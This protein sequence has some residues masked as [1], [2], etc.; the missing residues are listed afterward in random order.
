MKKYIAASLCIC[1]FLTLP[2]TA[3]ASENALDFQAEYEAMYGEAPVALDFTSDADYR[4]AY[5]LWLSGLVSYI[6]RRTTEVNQKAAQEAAQQ[7][8]SENP[9]E[10]NE[11]AGSNHVVPSD[12]ADPPWIPALLISILSNHVSLSISVSFGLGCLLV[13]TFSY[14]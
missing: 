6:D 3:F 9:P 14:H 7:P 5:D 8:V 10:T 13:P 1:L 2:A 4:A 11:S 12:H